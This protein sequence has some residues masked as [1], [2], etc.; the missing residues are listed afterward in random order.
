MLELYERGMITDP[1]NTGDRIY[2]RSVEGQ[3]DNPQIFEVVWASV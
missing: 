2:A 1:V 3:G